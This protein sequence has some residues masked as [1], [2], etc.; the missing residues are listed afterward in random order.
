MV[1]IQVLLF[2][3]H[4]QMIQINWPCSQQT[5]CHSRESTGEANNIHNGS[6]P[7]VIAMLFFSICLLWKR[8][9]QLQFHSTFFHVPWLEITVVTAMA[10][11]PPPKGGYPPVW[12]PLAYNNPPVDVL[13]SCCCWLE[14]HIWSQGYLSIVTY[15]NAKNRDTYRSEL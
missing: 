4:S 1:T 14:P 12:D 15:T 3:C 10:L 2:L 8:S 11:C 6:G 9:I 7:E 13:Q 5:F